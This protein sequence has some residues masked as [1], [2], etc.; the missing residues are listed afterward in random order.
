MSLRVDMSFLPIEFNLSTGET[1]V[2][3]IVLVLSVMNSRSDH[4]KTIIT[5]DLSGLIGKLI[6]D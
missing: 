1:C 3:F 5:G 4:D 2:I 6:P